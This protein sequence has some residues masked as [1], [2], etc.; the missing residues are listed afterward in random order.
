[1]GLG[2]IPG[3][4]RARAPERFAVLLFFCGVEDEFMLLKLNRS[5]EYTVDVGD[6]A[7]VSFEGEVVVEIGVDAGFLSGAARRVRGIVVFLRCF[8]LSWLFIFLL[9]ELRWDEREEEE[10][11][12][13]DDDDEKAY[14]NEFPMLKGG[15]RD[16]S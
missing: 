6:V 8:F 3:T 13:D 12:D 14:E 7:T 15:R 5:D 10:V 11:G 4:N 16:N 2:L 1:M 9:L